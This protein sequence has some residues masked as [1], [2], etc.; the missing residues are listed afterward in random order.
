MKE[1]IIIGRKGEALAAKIMRSKGHLIRH[2]NLR[3]GRFEIDLV[4]EHMNILHFVEVKTMATKKF[5]YPEVH[6]GKAKQQN[7]HQAVEKYIESY[8]PE[9]PIQFDL[10]A[11]V[12]FP[13][14]EYF[15]FEDTEFWSQRRCYY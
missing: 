7:I 12:L 14:P 5:G 4:T 6:F 8:K 1:H 13:A 15:L 3:L 2:K 9:I 11:I 10:L